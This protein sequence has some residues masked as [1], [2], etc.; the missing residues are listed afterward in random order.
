MDGW[1]DG[2]DQEATQWEATLVPG[3]SH[4]PEELLGGS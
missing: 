4:R 3:W 1:M 2:E